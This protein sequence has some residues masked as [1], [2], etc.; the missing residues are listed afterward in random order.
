MR[1]P[2]LGDSCRR[3]SFRSEHAS[4][5]G[6]RGGTTRTDSRRCRSRPSR[7]KRRSGS[8]STG[9]RFCCQLAAHIPQL[10]RRKARSGAGRKRKKK[11]SRINIQP[12]RDLELGH[13]GRLLLDPEQARFLRAEGRVEGADMPVDLLS[14]SAAHSAHI[15]ISAD[16]DG[17]LLLPVA[18]EVIDELRD[19][20][21]IRP[22]L[23]RLRG[24]ES[25][26]RRRVG[27]K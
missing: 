23:G 6:R 20:A 17:D 9:A 8:S 4:C 19:L 25:G 14:A 11:D 3:A 12:L 5:R 2:R 13:F 15:V 16:S 21:Q 24:R 26:A 27:R 18:H 10:R 1:Q 7:R 22:L